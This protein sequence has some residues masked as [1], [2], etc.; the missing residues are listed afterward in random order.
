MAILIVCRTCNG[1]GKIK[2]VPLLPFYTPCPACNGTGRQS[3]QTYR[4]EEQ[5]R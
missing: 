4:D 3:I 2:K 1:T 5:N